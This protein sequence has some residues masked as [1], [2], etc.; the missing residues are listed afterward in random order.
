MMDLSD[1]LGGDIFHLTTESRCGAILDANVIPIAIAAGP[2]ANDGRSPLDHA[3]NDGEDFELLFS[4]PMEAARQLID[5]Q[6]L[7][8]LGVEITRIGEMVADFGVWIRQGDAIHALPRG[9]FVHD[10]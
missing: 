6:P 5:D 10:V 7:G 2:T 8:D 4:L 3:L 1:G 9:G